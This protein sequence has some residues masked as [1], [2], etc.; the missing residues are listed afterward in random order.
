MTKKLKKYCCPKCQSDY[1]ESF[2][3][4]SVDFV[5]WDAGLGTPGQ[6]VFEQTTYTCSDCEYQWFD[7]ESREY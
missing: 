4:I 1:I 6:I 3:D 7:T 2:S 5:D